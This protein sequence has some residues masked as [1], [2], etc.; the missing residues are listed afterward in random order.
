MTLQ[1]SAPI[2]L[3]NVVTEFGSDGTP[4]LSDYTRGGSRVPDT[5]A[6]SSISATSS[7]LSLSQFYGGSALTVLFSGSRDTDTAVVGG[8]DYRY[9]KTP[10]I[11]DSGGHTWTFRQYTQG[12]NSGKTVI[13]INA[14][15]ADAYWTTIIWGPSW[16]TL[17][18]STRES[19]TGWDGAK[20]S[21]LHGTKVIPDAHA[22]EQE[23][24]N[25]YQ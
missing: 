6:N 14:D 20:T 9:F 13:E 18:Q 19:Y 23:T 3:S 24:L 10:A 25:I 4:Q 1:T 16:S 8:D 2:S 21:W 22:G 5:S 11:V 12:A 7:G 17:Q 15:V